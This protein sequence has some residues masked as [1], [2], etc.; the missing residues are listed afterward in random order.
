MI[1]LFANQSHLLFHAAY[2]QA[3]RG[4]Q[5]K[6]VQAGEPESVCETADL[7]ISFLSRRIMKGAALD[8]PNI[9]LHPGSPEYRSA[10]GA[11]IA[12]FEK[13]PTYGATSHQMV[14]A[15]DAGPIYA[16]ERFPIGAEDTCAIVTSNSHHA[17][18]NLLR[19][20][21][22]HWTTHGTVPPF[23]NERWSDRYM[24]R[25]EFDQ[26]LILD[27]NNLEE[28]REK[29]RCARHPTYAGPY[30]RIGGILFELAKSER[31]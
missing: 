30:V 19:D 28:L 4:G 8:R 2:A 20:F 27:P 1:C 6:V 18:L 17:C 29:V 3:Q 23:V 7:V 9:N 14:R 21:M 12:M 22:D 24:T 5:V 16:V 11:S 10:A 31:P 25:K 15:I 13:S 26:W